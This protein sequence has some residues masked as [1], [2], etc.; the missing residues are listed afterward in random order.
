MEKRA[1]M[2]FDW[3]NRLF[4][5][6]CYG[7]LTV[8]VLI[9]VVQVFLRYVL[10][11]PVSWSEEI[12]LLLLVWFGMLAVAIAVFRHTHMVIS[13][14][15]DRFPPPVQHVV[16]IAVELLIIIFAL[17]IAINAQL[18]IDI[19]GDQPLSASEL[20]KAWLYYPLQFGGGLMAFNAI[21]NI[22]LNHF[23]GKIPGVESC[24]S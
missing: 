1:H 7:L 5:W 3:I 19:V 9:T 17:N 14:V 22:L 21:G 15:W 24:G 18:L 16:N 8:L 23:P 10:R 20:P 12:A 13:V 2:V 11:S 4:E 6:V